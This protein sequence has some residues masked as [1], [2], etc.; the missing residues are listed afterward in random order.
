M[1]CGF[2]EVSCYFDWQSRRCNW[3]VFSLVW[4]GIN[5]ACRHL[6]LYLRPGMKKSLSKEKRWQLQNPELSVT[7]DGDLRSSTHSLSPMQLFFSISV[8]YSP[9]HSLLCSSK[10]NR[11]QASHR[12]HRSSRGN[13]FTTPQPRQ[14]FAENCTTMPVNH[15]KH[16]N[17]VWRHSR[18]SC[19]GWRGWTRS[20]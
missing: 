4:T 16:I 14:C 17:L 2:Y 15:N 11:A 20:R 18:D 10:Q 19:V 1:D 6:A 3:T 9:S 13:S 12:S 8:W 7:A 5:V